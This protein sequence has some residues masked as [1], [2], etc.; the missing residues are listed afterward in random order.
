MEYQLALPPDLGLSPADFVT[1]W[2]ASAVC[3]SIAQASL[4]SSTRAQYDPLLVG[5]IAV[6]SSIGIGLA[7]NALYDLI[8]QVLT[9]KGV[10]TQTKIMKIDQPDG[11]HILVVTIDEQ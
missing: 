11:T 10:H 8:K 5:A 7:T 6:L 4:A 1:A 2:N 3:R 9:T